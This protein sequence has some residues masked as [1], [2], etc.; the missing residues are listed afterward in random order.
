[1]LQRYPFCQYHKGSS[2]VFVRRLSLKFKHGSINWSHKL[3]VLHC[4]WS[5]LSNFS[6]AWCVRYFIGPYL[7]EMET[8][9]TTDNFMKTRRLPKVVGI[10]VLCLIGPWNIHYTRYQALDGNDWAGRSVDVLPQGL[11]NLLPSNL[12]W[13]AWVL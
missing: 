12:T 2:L 7:K 5:D 3:S 11:S 13:F 10:I 4:I 1:M 8:N 6:W 9:T